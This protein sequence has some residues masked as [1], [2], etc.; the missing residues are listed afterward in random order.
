[1]IG[2]NNKLKMENRINEILEEKK[3]SILKLSEM[4]NKNYTSIHQLVTR[5]DLGDTKAKTLKMVADALEV[6]VTDLW[7]D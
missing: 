3:I 2:G 6:K 1:M 5:D 7:K 4:V